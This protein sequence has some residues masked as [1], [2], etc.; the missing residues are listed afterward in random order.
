[1]PDNHWRSLEELRARQPDGA[2]FS[3]TP[4]GIKSGPDRRGFLKAAGFTFAGAMLAGC[5]R[6]APKIVSN[7]QQPEGFIPGRSVYY[8]SVCTACTAA[9]GTLVK[10]RDGRPIKLEGNPDHPVSRGGL[11]MVGQASLLGLYDSERVVQPAISGKAV[12]WEKLDEFVRARLDQARSSRGAVRVLTGTVHGPTESAWIRRFVESFPNAR[13]IEYDALSSSAILDAHEQTHGARILPRYRFDKADVIVSIDADFLG[14]WISPVE[15]TEGYSASRIPDATR[16]AWHTQVESRMSTTGTKADER[17][18]LAPSEM[19]DFVRELRDAVVS[20]QS[21][22]PRVDAI[23]RRLRDARGRGLVVSGLQDVPCQSLVNE[24][25]E[26]LGNY[27]STVETERTSRQRSGNDRGLERLLAELGSGVVEVLIVAG[28]N[29]VFELPG[30]DAVAKAKLLISYSARM[31][32]TAEKAHAV[33]AAP[34]G[35]ESWGDAEPVDGIV[36]ILQPCI[37]PL[38]KTRP[39]MES[40]AAWSGKPGQSLDLIREHWQKEIHPRAESKLAFEHFWDKALQDGFVLYRPAARARIAFSR[41]TPSPAGAPLKRANGFEIVLYAKPAILEGRQAYNPWLHE[42]PDPVTKVCWDNYA[43][44]A[45]RAAARLGIHDGD[46]VRVQADGRVAELPALVQ[47]GQADNTVAVALGY[48]SRLSARFAK[49]GPQWLE[50]KPT[51]NER[52]VVGVNAS[53]MLGFEGGELSY[54]R[55]GVQISKTNKTLAL[56]CTQEHHTVA[57]PERLAPAA[58]PTRPIV[59]ETTL[60]EIRGAGEAHKAGHQQHPELWPPDHPYPVHRWAMVVD[61]NACTGCSACVVACQVENNTPVVG[62]DEMRRKREMHW[63]RIDRYYSGAADDPKVAH[64]PMFC[65][66][67]EHAPCETVCPVLATVHNDEGL[68]QQVYNRCVGTRYCANNCPYKVRRFNWFDYVHEDRVANLVLNPDVTV[69]SRGVMEKCTF[70]VHRIQES[71][72]E[73]RRTGRTLRDGDV[74]AACQQSCPARAI[75]FGDL[76]D[77]KSDVSRLMASGRRYR[78]LEEIN[79]RPSVGYLKVVRQ[80]AP[81]GVEKQ[82]V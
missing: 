2:E 10:V 36:S 77:P 54:V 7:V 24:I 49:V 64:Q 3:E 45:P 67:C 20:A 78:V 25:N 61:L 43:C 81:A 74:Q 9:C 79:V 8:A 26:A 58:G 60:V 56:A 57:V 31:D 53:P 34:D 37:R 32:E 38:F 65:Q 27:G 76:N 12:G 41:K 44:L 17:I 29:P 5:S 75:V 23:A 15:Y 46:V 30:G 35:L 66:Q 71:R 21:A 42:I 11:C 69:R 72:I 51:L 18:V 68:N 14:T 52:G 50:A 63:I 28:V 4:I 59:Q 22:L 55:A 33:C 80:Q 73:S 40:M 48:G 39:L 13:H 16:Y 1:M 70:C 19:P 82:H 62:K 47:P 6:P